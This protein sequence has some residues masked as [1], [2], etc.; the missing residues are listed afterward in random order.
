M[1]SALLELSPAWRESRESVETGKSVILIA[2]RHYGKWPLLEHYASTYAAASGTQFVRFSSFISP[3]ERGIDYSSLWERTRS[4]LS[5]RKRSRVVDGPS[6]EYAFQSAICDRK[7]PIIALIG[8]ARR[9][10]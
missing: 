2:P 1:K 3:M 7:Q 8:G 5:V 4:Q 10:N 9:G 6:F